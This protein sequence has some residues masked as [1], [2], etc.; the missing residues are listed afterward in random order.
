MAND[1]TADATTDPAADQRPQR[2]TPRRIA[3]LIGDWARAVII[4]TAWATALAVAATVAV[5]VLKCLLFII[6]LGQQ[7]LFP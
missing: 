3:F 5:L 7:A 1:P 2:S 4:I 6:N